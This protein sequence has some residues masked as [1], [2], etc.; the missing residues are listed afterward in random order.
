LLLADFLDLIIRENPDT[1]IMFK[2]TFQL[3]FGFKYFLMDTSAILK[4]EIRKLLVKRQLSYIIKGLDDISHPQH[5]PYIIFP[6]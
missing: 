6:H 2:D 1:F 4:Q 5:M 3:L